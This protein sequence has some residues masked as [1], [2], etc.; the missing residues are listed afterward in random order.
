VG[1][2][3][4]AIDD[5]ERVVKLPQNWVPGLLRI[6]PDFDPIRNNPRFQKLVVG[7]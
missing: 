5:L 6:D 1:D 4:R 3:E 2:Y 7:A